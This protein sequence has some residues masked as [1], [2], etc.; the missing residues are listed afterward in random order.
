MHPVIAE[1]VSSKGGLSQPVEV[2]DFA[3]TADS[4]RN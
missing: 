4:L 2:P 1:Y 3:G